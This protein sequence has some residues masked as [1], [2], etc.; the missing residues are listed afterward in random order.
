VTTSMR[1]V[2]LE[3]REKDMLEFTQIVAVDI[4]RKT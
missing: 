3:N 4:E 1:R 2:K